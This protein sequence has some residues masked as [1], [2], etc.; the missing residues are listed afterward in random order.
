MFVKNNFNSLALFFG[1]LICTIFFTYCLTVSG[2]TAPLD[3]YV[4]KDFSYLYGNI[5][6]ISENQ[7]KQHYE[8]YKGYIDKVNE[9]N[10]KVYNAD[11][12]N[13]S[14]TYSK[15]RALE[16]AKS[17]ANNGA[18][19]HELYFSNLSTTKQNPTKN[20]KTIISRDF[21][22][23]DKYIENLKAVAKS[24]RGWVI[25]A[26]NKRDNKVHNYIIDEHDIYYPAG[27]EPL[28]VM[29]V[30]EHSYMIDYGINRSAYI[31]A[32]LNNVNWSEVDK[33]LTNAV[34]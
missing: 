6:G 2:Q 33:R 8:L 32:F 21:G 20:F 16:T 1:L 13:P 18:L 3:T 17:F 10:Q 25:T 28:L 4:A 31:E 9:I 34:K 14:T 11:L 12:S 23:W 19:L 24:S 15:I 30:W 7:L 27:V 22:G 26:F 5:E 29:D